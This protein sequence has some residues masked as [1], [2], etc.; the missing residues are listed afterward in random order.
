[1]ARKH[2]RDRGI[3]EKPQGSNTWWVRIFVN[4]PQNPESTSFCSD[5]QAED[6]S[7]PPFCRFPYPVEDPIR[8]IY[9]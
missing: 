1:M 3:L 7:I 8:A 2:G 5:P 9:Q 4:G 6:V